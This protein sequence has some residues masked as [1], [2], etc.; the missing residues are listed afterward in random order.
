[1]NGAV[2]T[3][4]SFVI[5]CMLL[6]AAPGNAGE[7][8]RK[9][10]NQLFYSANT[11]YEHG[12]YV[13]ALENYDRLLQAGLES[14]RLYYNI[15]NSFFKIGKVGYAILF[16]EKAK[17]LIPRDGDLKS[18]LAHAKSLVGYSA[19]QAPTENRW[20][21]IILKPYEDFNLN[22]ITIS[23]AF[24]YLV[25][26]FLLA[27]SVFNPIFIRKFRFVFWIFIVLFLANT[28]A[29]TLRYYDEEILDH[30][31]VVQKEA[32]CKYE[33]IDKSTT[34]YKLQE[35]SEVIILK[36]RNGWTQIKRLDGKIAWIKKEAV[37][38]INPEF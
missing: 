5:A 26:I 4:L 12:D 1:M 34:Y 14:G 38:E 37:A 18:N 29:F 16:Y 30:G 15:G 8:A 22:A 11:Y 24:L 2:R 10:Y 3:I 7:E 27:S 6:P 35:G 33:P 9:D 36:T 21:K 31:I 20:T 13:K 17:R 23:G 25:L 19:F 28:G 32:E